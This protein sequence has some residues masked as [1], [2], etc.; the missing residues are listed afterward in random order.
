M[1]LLGI[2]ALIS[3]YTT[4]VSFPGSLLFVQPFRPQTFHPPDLFRGLI[5]HEQTMFYP[6]WIPLQYFVV[7]VWILL[8]YSWIP[9]F[10]W[11]QIQLSLK[12]IAQYRI[13]SF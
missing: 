1:I 9:S 6:G 11:N 8:L 12:D 2:I 3:H 13:N 5:I 7:P 4:K 10:D